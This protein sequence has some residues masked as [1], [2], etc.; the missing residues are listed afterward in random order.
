MRLKLTL[1]ILSAMV[2]LHALQPTFASA[3]FT[4]PVPE[5]GADAIGGALALVAGGLAVLRDRLR[6][7]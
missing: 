5:I 7:R 2:A 1:G 6:R 3:V 4:N